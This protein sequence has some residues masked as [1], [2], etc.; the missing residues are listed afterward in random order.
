LE[1][2]SLSFGLPIYRPH[3]SM[4]FAFFALLL[5]VIVVFLLVGVTEIAFQ[6]IG[7]TRF[8][9]VLILIGT[10][11]GSSVNIPFHRLKSVNRILLTRYRER[12]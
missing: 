5:S 6:R 7:F 3:K 11:L 1:G 8:E 10:F 12:L 2:L 9:V 4:F